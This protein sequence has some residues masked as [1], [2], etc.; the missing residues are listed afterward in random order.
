MRNPSSGASLLELREKLGKGGVPYSARGSARSSAKSSRG[1]YSARSGGNT[2][3]ASRVANSRDSARGVN[4]AREVVSRES[5]TP[6]AG[7]PL[8]Q[9]GSSPKGRHLRGV[10]S[11]PKHLPTSGGAAAEPQ[12]SQTSVSV[13]AQGASKRHVRQPRAEDISDDSED[14]KGFE[15]RALELSE[16][17]EWGKAGVDRGGAADVSQPIPRHAGSDLGA[18]VGDRG[19]AR[20]PG[21]GREGRQA[22]EKAHGEREE[23]SEGTP[24]VNAKG[25]Q[26]ERESHVTHGEEQA[27]SIS[28]SVTEQAED[29][30]R[31]YDNGQAK[32]ES[33]AHSFAAATLAAVTLVQCAWRG[34]AARGEA[35]MRKQAVR[36]ERLRAAVVL[37]QSWSRGYICRKAVWKVGGRRL[38]L[39]RAARARPML[40][41]GVGDRSGGQHAKNGGGNDERRSTPL[42]GSSIAA[43]EGISRWNPSDRLPSPCNLEPKPLAKGGKAG[44]QFTPGDL[45]IDISKAVS[46]AGQNKPVMVLEQ[47]KAWGGGGGGRENHP[48][49]RLAAD[50]EN[51]HFPTPQTHDIETWIHKLRT[52][53]TLSY[54]ADARH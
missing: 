45:R 27:A 48:R 35:R 25:S 26:S 33:E 2:R 50:P 39:L 7:E 21:E 17:S 38:E 32:N 16:L 11:T 15:P 14:E 37:V 28:P 31:V 9:G 40:C 36:L 13:P 20:K 12:L 8:K 19:G 42:E 18:K 6:S 41:A 1:A 30:P 46:L 3:K 24:A 5:S 43:R 44:I 29:E 22:E 52:R 53:N 23:G 34:Y 47:R 51:L 54:T 49:R 4:S 10:D